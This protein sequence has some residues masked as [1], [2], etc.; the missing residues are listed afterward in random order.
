MH[1]H[2]VKKKRKTNKSRHEEFEASETYT[3]S[4]LNTVQ[5]LARIIQR[6]QLK[7]YLPQFLYT[8]FNNNNNKI[9]RNFK[10]QEKNIVERDK[11]IIRT[12]LRYDIDVGITGQRT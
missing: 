11:A 1:A 5:H 4:A 12:R 9:K 10:S 2:K 7:T 6:Q 8:A 3:T